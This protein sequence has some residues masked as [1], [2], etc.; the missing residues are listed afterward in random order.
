MCFAVGDLRPCSTGPSSFIS[1]CV[2]SF[3][4]SLLLYCLLFFFCWFLAC[5]VCAFSLF[6]LYKGCKMG[7]KHDGNASSTTESYS[8][9]RGLF[10]LLF[11]P[12]VFLAAHSHTRPPAAA[13]L[14]LPFCSPFQRFQICLI[15]STIVADQRGLP[16]VPGTH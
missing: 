2:P 5:V 11:Y 13:T 6:P 12:P 16:P 15:Q 3:L 1:S 10:L 8:N 9:Y 14:N 4:L 7:I